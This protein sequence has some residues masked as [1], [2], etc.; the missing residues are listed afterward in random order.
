M[1]GKHIQLPFGIVR[2]MSKERI[3]LNLP[4]NFRKDVLFD[5][6][7][8]LAYL[9]NLA[10]VDFVKNCIVDAKISFSSWAFERHYSG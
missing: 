9:E 8:Y 3:K 10:I 5:Q 2:G 6:L 4:S 7:P 1:S